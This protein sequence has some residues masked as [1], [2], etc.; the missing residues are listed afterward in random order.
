VV[1]LV[2]IKGPNGAPLHPREAVGVI[3]RS[4]NDYWHAY[5]VRFP[6]HSEASLKRNEL[7][8]LKHFNAGAGA[9]A[10]AGADERLAEFNLYDRVIYR[11]V[12]G[13]RAYGLDDSAS[14]TD[15]RGVYLPPARLHWSLFG[16]PEQIENEE[17]QETYW[18]IQKFLTLALKANPNI[19]E[20]LY[21]PIVEHMADIA[22]PILEQRQIFL[23]KMVYQTYNGY[24]LSQFKKLQA[25]L[26]NRGEAKW[27][28]IMHLLR[29]LLAGIETLRK[30]RVPVRVEDNAMRERLLSIKRGEIPLDELERW[31]LELHAQFDEAFIKT[32]LPDRPDYARANDLLLAARR[33]AIDH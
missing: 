16:V 20:C 5:R 4:P 6:D 7:S 23:S 30:Q 22:R 28:H 13:S 21:S 19:L 24:V 26:R 17:T 8:I 1:A 10:G 9:G 18:E 32:K 25:D 14:D 27:K 29:L 3:V 2:A 12:I 15:R 11:C 33:H 31:R